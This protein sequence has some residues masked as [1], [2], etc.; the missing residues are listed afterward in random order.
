MLLVICI[1]EK[2]YKN[3]CNYLFTFLLQRQAFTVPCIILWTTQLVVCLLPRLPQKIWT[4]W[5][6]THRQHTWRKL[7]WRYATWSPYITMQTIWLDMRKLMYFV[8]QVQI[9]LLPIYFKTLLLFTPNNFQMKIF[10]F[11]QVSYCSHAARSQIVCKMFQH[12][13]ILHR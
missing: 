10:S 5:K 4:I 11:N 3:T 13:G 8:G 6:T 12:I 9:H 7:L 1:E 2:K